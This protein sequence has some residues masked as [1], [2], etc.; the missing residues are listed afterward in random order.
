MKQIV[1][2]VLFLFTLITPVQVLAEEFTLSAG[3]S[4]NEL[5]SVFFGAW[6]VS[7]KLEDTNS[8]S[9]FKPQSVDIWNLSR[10]GDEVTLTNPFNGANAVIS[11]R[12]VEGNVIVFSKVA[13]YDNK[14][15]TDT[16]SIRLENGKF[17]GINT[18]KL[19]SYS[20]IDKH[21]MKT[22]T[23]RYIISGEK[24]SGETILKN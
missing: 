24:I 17:K 22:E 20:L 6:R 7:A 3:V 9:T 16:V 1:V 18:I 8:Y 5:P 15:L 19:E 21:L 2:L 14:V 4:V 11:L 12:A 23:A 10:V 13:P